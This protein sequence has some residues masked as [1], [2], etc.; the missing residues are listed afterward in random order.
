[1]YVSFFMESVTKADPGVGS[2]LSLPGE[3]VSARCGGDL[4]TRS[5]VSQLR[6]PCH[7]LRWGDAHRPSL[8]LDPQR[9]EE[10]LKHECDVKTTMRCTMVPPMRLDLHHVH[11]SDT[12][13]L[14]IHRM[15]FLQTRN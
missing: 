7:R 9:P 8:F 4:F 6:D 12:R 3:L 15:L 2:P 11:S 5:F 14:M 1:V 13:E 10:G